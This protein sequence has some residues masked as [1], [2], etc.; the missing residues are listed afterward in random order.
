M[1][2]A[3]GTL[4]LEYS[5]T[6]DTSISLDI[7]HVVSISVSMNKAVSTIPLVSMGVDRAFQLETGSSL[8]YNISF[9]RKN[10]AEPDNTS[11]DTTRWSNAHWYYQMN[12]ALDR[13]QMK[14]DGFRLVYKPD[15]TNPYVP[16]IDANGYIRTFTRRY[17]NK[18]NEL[19]EGSMTFIVG[20]MHVLSSNIRQMPEV[21]SDYYTVILKSADEEGHD[22]VLG[23][24]D[25]IYTTDG[26]ALILPDM[27]PKWSLYADNISKYLAGW[28]RP[29]TNTT[30]GVG[31]QVTLSSTT[32]VLY[33]V[34]QDTQEED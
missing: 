19:I 4:R 8:Q 22:T 26:N 27:P 29:S 23:D 31:L 12:K 32:T 24:T 13:W 11:S 20:T 33:G 6:K 14:S 9:R 7:G 34:W 16:P 30:L 28:K 1:T 5:T 17:T 21:K 10:P 25:V 15:D 3:E 18:F 2:D